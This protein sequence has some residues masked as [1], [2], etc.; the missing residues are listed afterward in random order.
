A[1]APTGGP[2]GR[3]GLGPPLARTVPQLLGG[4]TGAEGGCGA[5]RGEATRRI[6][7]R[8]SRG[9][10]PGLPAPPPQPPPGRPAPDAPE[11]RAAPGTP[12]ALSV[13][14]PARPPRDEEAGAAGDHESASPPR[15]GMR[16]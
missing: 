15:G 7:G 4:R 8:R 3:S 10:A 11:R 1:P 6:P 9:I 13:R 5:G 16:R 14:L 2:A 12:R